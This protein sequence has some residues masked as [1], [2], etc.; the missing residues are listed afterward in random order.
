M[1]AGKKK[2]REM[3]HRYD[4]GGPKLPLRVYGKL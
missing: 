2:E 3:R 4:I 1:A